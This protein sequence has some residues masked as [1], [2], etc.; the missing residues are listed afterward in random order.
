MKTIVS[1]LYALAFVALITVSSRG[2]A[3]AAP[4]ETPVGT[5]PLGIAFSVEVA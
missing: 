3:G 4:K 5:K 1:S 2:E